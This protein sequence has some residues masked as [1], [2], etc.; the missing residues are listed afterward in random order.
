MSTTM[1][2]PLTPGRKAMLVVGGIFAFALIAIGAWTA[3]NAL[4]TTTEERH[5]VLAPTGGR[6]TIDADGAIQISTGTGS[7]VEITERIRHS[8]GRPRVQET[9]TGGGVTLK[10]DCAWYTST[11]LVSFQVTIP[12]GLSV[13]AR[14]SAGDIKVSGVT[15]DIRLNTSG[16]DV[17]A[18]D[19]GSNSVDARSSAGDVELTFDSPPATVTAHSSAGDVNVWL[20]R[21]DGGYRVRAGTSAGKQTVEVPT[22]PESTRVI[23]A[24]TSAGDVSV[25]SR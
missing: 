17:H 25:K 22:D 9:S 7:Q 16:G 2:R 20:P 14:S 19:L 5:L 13:D 10:G 21:V 1:T 4:G 24:T 12:P 15:G 23:D 8:I 11:C 18:T 6:L 3:I